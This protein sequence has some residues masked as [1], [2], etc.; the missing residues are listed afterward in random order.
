MGIQFVPYF[1]LNKR[2]CKKNK[3]MIEMKSQLKNNLILIHYLI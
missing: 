1:D 3:N 2:N